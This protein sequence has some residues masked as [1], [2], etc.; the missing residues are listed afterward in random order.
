LDRK[1]QDI[2]LPPRDPVPS[3]RQAREIEENEIKPEAGG[4]F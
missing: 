1:A 3:P 2:L 4:A